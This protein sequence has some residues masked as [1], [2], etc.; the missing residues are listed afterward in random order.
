MLVHVLTLQAHFSFVSQ[1]VNKKHFANPPL[2]R[3]SPLWYRFT[4]VLPFSLMRCS[5]ISGGGAGEDTCCLTALQ[6]CCIG[7]MFSVSFL[8]AMGNEDKADV[9]R[10]LMARS[11]F[12]VPANSWNTLLDVIDALFSLGMVS[13]ST[14]PTALTRIHSSCVTLQ[15]AAAAAADEHQRSRR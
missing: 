9:G 10:E 6:C 5:M 11:R 2:P 7:W 13:L 4:T 15:A 8:K 14:N 12:M 3:S 1:S